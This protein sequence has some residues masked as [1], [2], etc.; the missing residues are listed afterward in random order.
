MEYSEDAVIAFSRRFLP[1]EIPEIR[2]LVFLQ[3]LFTPNLCFLS[4]PVLVVDPGYR[5][6]MSPE[7]VE[8]IGLPAERAPRI[9]EDVL[10]LT[11]LTVQ[12]KQPTT[13]NLLAPVVVS[14]RDRRAVQAISADPAYS[15][16]HIFLEPCEE[17]AVCS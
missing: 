14:L 16:R 12:E 13:A 9:G 8:A 4:L 7:D 5:L 3:S 11:L 15:H 2:P 17:E 1:I 6:A 10:C